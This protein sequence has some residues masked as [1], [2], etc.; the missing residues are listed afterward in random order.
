MNIIIALLS[1][2]IAIFIGEFLNFTDKSYYG[3][4]LFWFI[5]IHLH[6]KT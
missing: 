1:S 5:L 3:M 4:F 2:I 6:Q